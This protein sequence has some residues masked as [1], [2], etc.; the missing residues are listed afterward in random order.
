MSQMNGDIIDEILCDRIANKSKTPPHLQY[1][2][3]PINL[4]STAVINR[5]PEDDSYTI[6]VADINM[7]LDKFEL[8]MT[9]LQFESLL[10]LLDAID[11]MKLSQ[12]YRKWRPS[13]PIKGFF[14]QILL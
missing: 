5:K 12:P 9:R 2:L 3:W 7:N 11:R 13:L 8:R 10:L 4:T 6:P 1:I 14:S